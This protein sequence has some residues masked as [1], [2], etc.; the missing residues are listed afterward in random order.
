MAEISSDFSLKHESES[1]FY[2]EV[3]DALNN[4]IFFS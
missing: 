4:K 1:G 2:Q 3:I